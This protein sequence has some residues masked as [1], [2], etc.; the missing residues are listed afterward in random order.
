MTEVPTTPHLANVVS[1]N[2]LV[3]CASD[4][5]LEPGLGLAVVGNLQGQR[6]VA[7]LRQIRHGVSDGDGSVNSAVS[8][9][10]RQTT[11]FRF[12][13]RFQPTI[14]EQGVFSITV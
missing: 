8:S 6:P 4:L 2:G 9:V 13:V 3:L 7:D 12:Q 11:G 1:E 14:V 5:P 10:G